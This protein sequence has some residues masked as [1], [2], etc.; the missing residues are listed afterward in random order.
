[1]KATPLAPNSGCPGA[2]TP[3]CRV[4]GAGWTKISEVAAHNLGAVGAVGAVL[5]TE[6]GREEEKGGRGR[7]P[8]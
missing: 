1:M 6:G 2:R 4:L 7:T 8:M 3:G 5:T